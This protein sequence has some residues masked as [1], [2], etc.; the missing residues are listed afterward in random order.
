MPLFKHFAPRLVSIA[1]MLIGAYSPK[2]TADNISLTSIGTLGGTNSLAYGISGDGNTIVGY[3]YTAGAH[4]HAFYWTQPTGIIDLGTLGGLNSVAEAVSGDGSVII[5][6]AET[7]GI[8]TFAFRWTQA[9]GMVSLGTLGGDH[10]YAHGVSEDGSVVVGEADLP[11]NSGR[12]AFRWTQ[13]TGMV[14]LGT[15]GGATSVASGVSA[16]GNI[17]AGTSLI[18]GNGASNAFRWTQSTG[19]VSLGTLGGAGSFASGISADGSTIV[20]TSY[21]SGNSVG[22]AFR[23]TQ[24]T[25]MEDIGSLNMQSS[26]ANAV[27][28]NGTVIVGHSYV[29]NGATPPH[30]VRWTQSTGMQDINTLLSNAGITPP[31]LLE[32][33]VGISANGNYIAV[34]DVNNNAYLMV[35]AL[36]STGITTA[37][38]QQQA[39]QQLS[40]TMESGQI[41]G[42]SIANNLLGM[43][44]PINNT[45]YVYNGAMFG[46]ALGYAGGQ[47]SHNDITILG[48][49]AYG[50]QEYQNVS[51]NAATTLALGIRKA[52]ELPEKP[53]VK[54]YAELGSWVTPDAGISINR[55]YMNGTDTATGNGD[56]T[57]TQWAGYGKLGIAWNINNADQLNSWGKLSR[58]YVRFDGYDESAVSSNPFP[59]SVAGGT[60]RMD[61]AEIG[62]SWTHQMDK[63]FSVTTAAAFAHS[64][65]VQ[66]DLNVTV[67]PFGSTR[68]SGQDYTWGE[69]VLQL[70]TKL[71]DD[72][73]LNLAA[74]GTG[75]GGIETAVHGLAGFSYHF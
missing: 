26:S 62:L 31:T 44:Q 46:S 67:A 5:G 75:G 43:T 54:P 10:S 69:F 16:N 13:G 73:S 56:T 34:S 15:L 14:D 7:A 66:P 3:S 70:E 22:H 9:T 61:V 55:D 25:G 32:N 28:A 35:Y 68:A 38:A 42:H 58:E 23:W 65:D 45:Q 4:E 59:A 8:S 48:G 52:F 1:V 60:S 2:A 37:E 63:R 50:S 12:D 24:S 57:A 18:S 53:A 74:I 40:K 39:T 27:S 36:G 17:I 64:F 11:S 6:R 30:A 71:T 33:A 29:D 47:C 51:Q 41:G 21:V 20:G 72:V 19:M 49:I